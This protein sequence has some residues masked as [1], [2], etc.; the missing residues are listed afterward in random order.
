MDIPHYWAKAERTVYR[1]QGTTRLE[2]HLIVWR[3]SDRSLE[4]AQAR[5]QHE[6]ETRITRFQRGE[7]LGDYP[8]DIRPLREPVIQTLDAATGE[9][10]AVVTR[11][12]SGCLV[13]NTAQVMFIDLDFATALAGEWH[14]SLTRVWNWLRG[15]PAPDA[16]ERLLAR[17]QDWHEREA[18]DW[19]VRVYRTR[20]GFRLLVGQALFEPTAPATQDLLRRLGSDQRYARL[21]AVQACFRARLTPKPHRI[22]L[23]RPPGRYP[24]LTAD[25]IERQRQWE[26]I[27]ASRIGQFAVCQWLCDLGPPNVH[28]MVYDIQRFHDAHTLPPTN[29]PLA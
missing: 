5:A 14:N 3:G 15:K 16:Q 21:C 20:A 19:Q 28:P 13:L 10:V 18:R 29:K 25:D 1:G 8:G 17:I 4:E 23:A 26:T 22:G 27:Y 7:P 24:W 12:A 11:N 6:L 9:R 2:R